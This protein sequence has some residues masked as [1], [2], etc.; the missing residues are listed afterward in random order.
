MVQYSYATRALYTM[1]GIKSEMSW[2]PARGMHYRA[3]EVEAGGSP[4]TPPPHVRA[5]TTRTVV[6]RAYFI[7]G[8]KRVLYFLPR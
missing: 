3:V 8:E 6:S 5:F 1:G 4:S 2:D 7:T